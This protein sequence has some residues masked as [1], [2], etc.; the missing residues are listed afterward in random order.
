[1][2]LP[3]AQAPP[4]MAQG[5]SE[6]QAESRWEPWEHRLACWKRQDYARKIEKINFGFNSVLTKQAPPNLN[7]QE[8]ERP[9]LVKS[10]SQADTGESL[11]VRV[12]PWNVQSIQ[13]QA[14]GV[15]YSK[16]HALG[17]CSAVIL[18]DFPTMGQLNSH[19]PLY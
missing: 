10:N 11:G 6:R 17:M 8:T 9:F 19:F 1:M 3:S 12:S 7:V 14:C 2:N 5:E 13:L 16:T 15:P 4:C 18:W